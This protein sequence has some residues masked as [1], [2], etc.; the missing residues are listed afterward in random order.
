[1]QLHPVPSLP[2]MDSR[3]AI[4][5]WIKKYSLEF[6]YNTAADLLSIDCTNFLF[7]HAS[8]FADSSR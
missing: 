2:G 6:K 5:F 8:V 3:F 1:M 7:I 4:W